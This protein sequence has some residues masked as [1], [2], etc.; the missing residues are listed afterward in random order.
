MGRGEID[1]GNTDRSWMHRTRERRSVAWNR[2]GLDPMVAPGTRRRGFLANF[3]FS[4]VG[5]RSRWF[6][7]QTCFF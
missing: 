4:L 3:S 7:L 5:F 1:A 6:D 2:K